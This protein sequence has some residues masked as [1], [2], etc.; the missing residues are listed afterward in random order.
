MYAPE[1]GNILC[2]P[3][4][5][6][7]HNR[8]SHSRPRYSFLGCYQGRSPQICTTHKKWSKIKFSDKFWNLQQIPTVYGNL[9][10]NK[11]ALHLFGL[12]RSL[13][14]FAVLLYVLD[15]Q[16]FFQS[17]SSIMSVCFFKTLTNTITQLF[18]VSLSKSVIGK[19]TQELQTCIGLFENWRWHVWLQ[20]ILYR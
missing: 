16:V 12:F 17:V 1:N 11:T 10:W 4:G 13:E 14:I 6:S 20:E 8:H 18:V 19:R 15:N 9:P 7:G 3:P 5:R 2:P